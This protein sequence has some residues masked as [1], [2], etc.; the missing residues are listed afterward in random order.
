MNL[1]GK[2]LY[3][4]HVSALDWRS[5]AIKEHGGSPAAQRI[6]PWKSMNMNFH[7]YRANS[8]QHKSEDGVLWQFEKIFVTR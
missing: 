2:F 6:W 7:V 1:I 8:I 4:S 5:T 3:F